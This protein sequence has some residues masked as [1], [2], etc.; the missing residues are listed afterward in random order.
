MKIV[1]DSE[2]EL[3]EYIHNKFKESGVVCIDGDEPHFL[4]RQFNCGIYGIADLVSFTIRDYIQHKEIDV[5]V[6][7]L[8]K[9]KITSEAFAQVSRYA[10]GIRQTLEKIED[11]LEI[12][13]TCVLVGTEIDESCFILNQSE[14]LFYSPYFNLESGVEFNEQ[15]SG[16]HRVTETPIK[17]IIDMVSAFKPNGGQA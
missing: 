1:F 8:K 3:E 4:E 13:I 2:A 9:E 5:T 16:W 14:F 11:L 17:S 10:T 12:T 6:Y 7:E 15:S